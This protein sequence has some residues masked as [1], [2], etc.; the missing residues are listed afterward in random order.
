MEM[1]TP[2][3]ERD[4]F[5]EHLYTSALGYFDVLTMSLGL[6]LGLYRALADTG[7]LTSVELAGRAGVA[8]RYAREWLEQ[9]TSRGIVRADLSTEPPRFS[10]PPAHAEV[11]LDGDSL[12][13][14]GASVGQLMSLQNALGAVTDAFRSGGGVP[15]EAYGEAS[16]EGQ[17]AGNRPTFLTTMPNAWLPAI[18]PLHDRLV[19][20]PARVADVGCGTGW[21]SIGIARAYPFVE[22][23]GFD[24]DEISIQMARDHAAGAGIAD[25]VRFHREDA[26]EVAHH[27]PFD[28]AMAFE[29][30]H[31]MA[32]P[33]EVLRA[34]REALV[35]DGSM[36]VVDE[37]TNEAFTGE[38]DDHEA[39]FYGWS[40]L[41]CL[42]TG[43]FEQP[44]AGTG[45]V[46]RPSTIRRYAEEAGF[47]GFEILPIEHDDFRLYLLRR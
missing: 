46:M 47:S 18:G 11:L 42:P 44:S 26:A 31:D 8:E 45:T 28:A 33:V 32:R 22:V 37:R 38:R 23:D 9:Q 6:R 20:S 36:L 24:P 41:D 35:P 17:G 1:A 30:I 13:Y 10:L 19:A 5:A 12:A 14:M 29:C 25:R 15:Y 34:V 16:V 3:N 39:Y 27:G 7:A 21:S 43:M 2:E 4:G 40:V